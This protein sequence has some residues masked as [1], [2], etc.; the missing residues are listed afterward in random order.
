MQII[1]AILSTF[2]NIWDNID[3]SVSDIVKYF[4]YDENTDYSEKIFSK[5]KEIIDSLILYTN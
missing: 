3:N 5:I 4:K 1:N 2:K